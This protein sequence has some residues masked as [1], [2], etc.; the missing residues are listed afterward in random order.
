[1]N[2]LPILSSFQ[3]GLPVYLRTRGKEIYEKG[4]LR[5]L[6]FKRRHSIVLLFSALF[7]LQLVKAGLVLGLF[8]GCQHY[9]NDKVS[10]DRFSFRRSCS[11][12]D[13]TDSKLNETF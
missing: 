11:M 7:W 12:L 3:V 13:C 8:G 6:L 2:I 9:E 10:Y 4:E 5:V 1:M